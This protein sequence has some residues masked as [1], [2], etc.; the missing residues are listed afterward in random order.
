MK[1]T[2]SNSPSENI[3]IHILDLLCSLNTF[4]S[5]LMAGAGGRALSWFDALNTPE[6]FNQWIARSDVKKILASLT[7]SSALLNS[8]CKNSENSNLKEVVTGLLVPHVEA[9]VE[10]FSTEENSSRPSYSPEIF[11][12]KFTMV[13]LPLPQVLLAIGNTNP[14]AYNKII[15]VDHPQT[16]DK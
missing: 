9:F 14:D 11:V 13:L 3:H 4:Y 6:Y 1:D 16:T 8:C 10:L 12:K 7:K 5:L 2:S 15:C